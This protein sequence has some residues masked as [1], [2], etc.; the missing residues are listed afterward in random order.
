MF[1]IHVLILQVL[2]KVFTFRARAGWQ[3]I[4][5]TSVGNVRF[6]PIPAAILVMAASD[7]LRTLGIGVMLFQ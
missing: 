1:S 5:T 3:K 2:A 4:Y 6:P 7:P